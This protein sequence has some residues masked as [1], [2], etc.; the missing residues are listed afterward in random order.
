M[1]EIKS[2]IELVNDDGT[3]FEPP[4]NPLQEKW[5]RLYSP[6]P[7]PEYSQ[8]CDGYSCM[9]CGRCPKGS[10]WKVPDEDKEVWDTYQK[11]LTAYFKEHNAC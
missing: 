10:Y 8:V 1:S 11:E 7:K 4:V 2:P 5:D 6:T 3:L 9:Y